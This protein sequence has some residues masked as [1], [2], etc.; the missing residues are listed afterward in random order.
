MHRIRVKRAYDEPDPG[1]GLRIL[2]DR[3]WP[4]G[5]SKRQAAVD[6]WLKEIAPSNALRK[7][8][9]HRPER[10]Q[11]FRQRYRRELEAKQDNVLELE[12]HMAEGPVTLLYSAKDTERNQALVLLEYLLERKTLQAGERH[13]SAPRPGSKHAWQGGSA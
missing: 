9:G 8:F 6:L 12:R 10:W 7:W 11:E 13:A 5:L 2:V 1:D 3:I 4:R